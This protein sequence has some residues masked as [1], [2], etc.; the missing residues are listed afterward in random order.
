V[1]RLRGG[2]GDRCGADEFPRIVVT[3]VGAAAEVA[4]GAERTGFPRLAVAEE[5][6]VLVLQAPS[7]T[8]IKVNIPQRANAGVVIAAA[9]FTGAN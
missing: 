4:L 8:L 5:A 1:E 6:A 2:R 7:L 3:A 9:V